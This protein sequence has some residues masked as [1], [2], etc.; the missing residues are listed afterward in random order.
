MS[1]KEEV[2]QFA[3]RLMRFVIDRVQEFE[4]DLVDNVRDQCFQAR[5]VSSHVADLASS[6]PNFTVSRN[7]WT[8]GL[9]WH[10]GTRA[11]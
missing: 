1:D 6:W 11:R 8:V 3:E 7:R 4:Q 9:G 2:Q 10:P 5:R